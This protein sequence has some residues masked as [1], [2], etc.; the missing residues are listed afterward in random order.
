MEVFLD[1]HDYRM[2][3]AVLGDTTDRYDVECRDYCVMPNHFHLALVNRQP[4]LSDAMQHL[5]GEY[6]RWWNWRHKHVGHVFGSPFKDQIV[7]QD[8]Y[9]LA[10]AKYIALNPVRAKLVERPEQWPWSAYHYVA[11]FAEPPPFLHGDQLLKQFGQGE[12]DVLR[13]RYTDYVEG[14]TDQESVRFEVFRSRQRVLGSRQFKCMLNGSRAVEHAGSV[15][16]GEIAT[17]V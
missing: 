11:G 10:L 1:D 7:E 5:K 6:A 13:K 15:A 3:F 8:T 2:F 17:S 12:V 9:A 16:E 14:V 4:N